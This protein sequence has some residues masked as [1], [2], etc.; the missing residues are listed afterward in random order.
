MKIKHYKQLII[1]SVFALAL[2][3][4]PTCS[5]QQSSSAQNSGG[6]QYY[7]FLVTY[8]SKINAIKLASDEKYPPII[9]SNNY[10]QNTGGDFQF[11]VK[12]LDVNKKY[13]TFSGGSDKWSLGDWSKQLTVHI[14]GVDKD[15][16]PTEANKVADSANIKV[17]VPYFS[18]GKAI[19]IYDAKSN[20]LALLVDVSKFAQ[21]APQRASSAHPE[22]KAIKQSQLSIKI[23][24][25]VKKWFW[26]IIITLVSIVAILA[27][28]YMIYR[29]KV[30]K[31]SEN[32]GGGSTIQFK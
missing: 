30:K 25:F 1:F 13:K 20:K 17:S 16:K 15:N 11:Y 31:A 26:Y 7:S 2:L 14:E 21:M 27:A 28:A 8:N 23:Q 24:M 19:E 3:A 22:I 12:L 6:G 4:L 32:L 9:S 10:L 18:D 29:A 5:A